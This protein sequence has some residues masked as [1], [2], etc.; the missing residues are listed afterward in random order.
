[1]PRKM[2]LNWFMPA[3]VNSKV[4]SERGTTGDEGT[5][6]VS[7]ELGA[8]IE[9]CSVPKEWPFFLKYS[10]KVSRTWV[11]V[12]SG[13]AGVLEA[14]LRRTRAGETGSR[15]EEEEERGGREEDLEGQTR[16]RCGG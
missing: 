13:L 5:R 14:I 16:E 12:H 15:E 1:M 3:L 4:G 7:L 9:I 8:R 2:D 10:R 6:G 11:E